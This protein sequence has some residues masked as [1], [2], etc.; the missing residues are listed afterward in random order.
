MSPRRF[1]L[2]LALPG[3]TRE[4]TPSMAARRV[5]FDSG[6]G[7]PGFRPAAGPR[8][9]PALRTWGGPGGAGPGWDTAVGPGWGR[10]R[11]PAA[12]W[13]PSA[14]A[15]TG[16]ARTT[17]WGNPRPANTLVLVLSPAVVVWSCARWHHELHLYVSFLLLL[18]TRAPCSLHRAGGVGPGERWGRRGPQLSWKAGWQARGQSLCLGW[19]WKEHRGARGSAGTW[20][21]GPCSMRCLWQFSTVSLRG[22]PRA[23]SHFWHKLAQ[24]WEGCPQAASS[25]Q[26][27]E[28]GAP[29][30]AVLW[31]LFLSAPLPALGAGGSTARLLRLQ[32]RKSSPCGCWRWRWW[33]RHDAHAPRTFTEALGGPLQ[34]ITG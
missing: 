25:R 17:R 1:G 19:C 31:S 30:H 33:G 21:L 5:V 26:L 11:A 3:P 29:E 22:C 8:Q 16:G 10:V 2:F 23:W 4:P 6:A 28:R 7:P 13:A 34:V 20:A 15:D 14:N 24:A 9:R 27:P 32:R 18:L 12:S